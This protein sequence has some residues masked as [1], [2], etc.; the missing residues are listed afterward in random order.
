[1]R[2]LIPICTILLSAF[3]MSAKPDTTSW[4]DVELRTP[5]G[6]MVELTSFATNG[7]NTIF[8]FWAS[9]CRPTTKALEEFQANY[10]EWQE[11]YNAEIVAISI[12]DMKSYHKIKPYVAAKGWE[13][14]VLCDVN[15]EAK[16]ALGVNN[17]PHTFI[18][19]THGTFVY[20]DTGAWR[21]GYDYEIE[22]VLKKH[23]KK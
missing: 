7:K 11:D 19:D 10:P 14:T 13:Y 2:Q 5:E 6:E 22:E 3:L 17:L 4:P 20:H 12:D 9:W 16:R 18:T 21:P 15:H 23:Y 8:I 1:M